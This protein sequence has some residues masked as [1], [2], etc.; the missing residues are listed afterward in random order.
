MKLYY[1]RKA[2]D[3]IYYIQQ[4]FRNG[5]KTSTRNIRRI[6]KHSELL[7]VTPDPLAYAKEQVRLMNEQMKSQKLDTTITIDFT[8][9]VSG[10]EGHVS[11]SLT[12][13][14][15]YFVLQKICSDLKIAAF[16]DEIQGETRTT[17]SCGDILRFLIYGRILDP[18]SKRGTFDRLETYYEA[19]SFSYHQIMRMMDLLEEH[20]GEYLRHLFEQSG[21]I[22]QRD[23]SVC[24]YDCTNYYFE[25]ESED[26]DLID[27]VTGEY[28]PGLRKYGFAKDHKPN[29]LVEMGLFM[30]RNGIPVSM[31]IHPGN[32]AEAST[33][34]PLEREV[35]Q[36]MN[37]K[38]VIYC[39]DAGLS[40][41]LIR[42]YN[43]MGG[44]RFVVTQSVKKLSETLQQAIFNDVDY[45]DLQTGKK[46]SLNRM[47]TEEIATLREDGS[48]E[49]LIVKEIPSVLRTELQGEDAVFKG[50]L[51]QR[52][53]VTFSRRAM[54][55]QRGIRN[56]QIER[57]KQMMAHSDPEAI[58]KGPNDVRRFLK[59]SG[60]GEKPVYELDQERIRQEEK[61]DGFYAVATNLEDDALTV[62]GINERRYKIEECFR[63][64]KTTFRTRP[65]FHSR[66]DRI[67]AHFLIC[68]SA[69]LVYR[70]L[71]VQLEMEQEKRPEDIRLHFTTNEILDT[72]RNMNICNFKDIFYQAT[73]SGGQ[74]LSALNDLQDLGLDKRY[75]QPK[76]L[77]KVLKK[78]SK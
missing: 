52:I 38:A 39:A 2:K 78:I 44:R 43:S 4:G 66:A 71:E 54:E 34:I 25:T 76:E 37:G 59:R 36:M 62:L 73:Y 63:I 64:M 35:V 57:A 51:N 33:A 70:L 28:C 42:Q 19:P 46:D 32:T 27:P 26:E 53:I 1:D 48:Y 12:R 61:Y 5:N 69:L 75:Y 14:I 24:Y 9:K 49:R 20:S 58:K 10:S 40:S 50:V 3:P 21:K 18:R 68:Y 77:R 6:G 7:A 72:L 11:A 41:Y 13:N 15:G 29:P 47:Q 30:D 17:F 16:M 45:T 65:V 74:V 23:T 60:D 22:V 55:Y 56:R 31:S 67:R 8:E